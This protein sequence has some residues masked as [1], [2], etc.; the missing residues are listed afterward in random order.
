VEV[1]RIQQGAIHVGA[2][3]YLAREE[4]AVDATRLLV[5]VDAGIKDLQRAARG[6]R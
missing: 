5:V 3:A 2:A 1:V 4:R 6:G